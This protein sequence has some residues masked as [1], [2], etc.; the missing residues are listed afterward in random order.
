MTKPSRA[1][2][3]SLAQAA[4]ELVRAVEIGSRRRVSLNPA[5]LA[6]SRRC[7]NQLAS[8]RPSLEAVARQI[9]ETL[10]ASADL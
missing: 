8:Q 1:V 3:G 5:P 9:N 2:D 10:N 4:G 6:C 7:G